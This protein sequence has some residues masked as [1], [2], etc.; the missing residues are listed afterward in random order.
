MVRASAAQADSTAAAT[1]VAAV[2]RVALPLPLDR[3]FDYAVPAALSNA[4]QAGC[5]VRVSAGRRRLNGIIVERVCDSQ[6]PKLREIE[7]VLDAEP[8]LTAALLGVLRAEAEALLCPIGIALRAALPPGSAP[9]ISRGF[10][11]TP[12]GRTA[13][14]AGALPAAARAVLAALERGPRSAAELTR[15]AGASP[16]LLAGLLRDGL[17]SAQ[18]IERGPRARPAVKRIARVAKGVDVEAA[19]AKELRRAPKQRE[20]LRKLQADGPTPL[21]EL[22]AGNPRATGL[23]HSLVQSGFA[24]LEEAPALSATGLPEADRAVTLLPEQRAAC[25]AIGAAIAAREPTPF[26]LHGVTGS[27][28]TEVYLRAVAQA[29]GAGRQAIVLV[30]E[31]TLTHQILGRLRA[32]F[33]DRLAV[34]HSGL[35]PGERLA[36]WQRLRRGEVEIAVGA[37][38]ALFAPARDLGVIVVDEEHDSAYKSEEG[39]RYHARHLAL[40]RAHADGCPL[41][42]GSATPSLEVRAAAQRGGVRHL[43]LPRRI[44]GQ[45]LPAVTLVDM[46][47]ERAALPRGRRLILSGALRSA[48]RETLADG[49]Q[50]I[51]FLNRRGFSTQIACFACQHVLRCR[52]CDIALTWHAAANL[53]RCH[54]CD[55]EI[56]PA[57]NC[58][59]CGAEDSALLGVGTERLEEEVRAHFPDARIARL[60]RDTAARRGAARALLAGLQS[61]EL[62]VLVGTQMVAKGHDF[63]GV[64]LVGVVNADLG[65]HFPDFR[66]AE[67]TFQLLTQVAG[68]AGRGPAPG[69]VV[70]QSYAPQHYAIRPVLQHDYES[71]YAE[72][73]RQRQ[74]HGYP[75]WGQLGLVRISGE[76]ESRA[77]LAAA[78]LADLARS[79]AA[80]CGGSVLGPAPA[81]IARLRGRHRFQFVVKHKQ[82][83]A[84]RQVLL[85]VRDAATAQPGALRIGVDPHPHDML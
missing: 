3:L 38:S 62:D 51:L 55:Y 69:R 14:H 59:S 21:R 9:R 64:R 53:L 57:S 28:K 7:A 37:R 31:I 2:A 72:E 68:R 4:A 40:R 49:A 16:G 36:Q 67:R 35:S 25:D 85:R 1:G 76:E 42:L 80:A 58:P 19:C 45:P 75:P 84:L 12:R 29:I 46:A 52:N 50:A 41:V 82:R 66:A 15:K 17:L 83:E 11:A 77:R 27:G 30:P 6:E 10:A 32:R 71:F 23:L 54:Y 61:G 47:A 22:R 18:S 56:R 39:F 60:D 24:A 73:M 20:L 13:L 5:R 48:L 79:A 63:A 70:V 8:V 44:G 43:R 74:A 78:E 81:P 26:L 65:L 33:G 34:L